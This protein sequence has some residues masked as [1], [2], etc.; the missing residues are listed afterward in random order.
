MVACLQVVT[1]VSSQDLTDVYRI[2][3]GIR[4][5]KVEG[6]KFLINNKPFYFKGFGKHEDA[7][8]SVRLVQDWRKEEQLRN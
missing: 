4:T 1:V 8:V 6:P 7:D 3:V 2:P 5:V